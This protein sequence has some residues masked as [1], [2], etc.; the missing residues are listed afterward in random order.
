MKEEDK[1]G[2]SSELKERLLKLAQLGETD[3]L[4]DQLSA[5]MHLLNEVKDWV[6]KY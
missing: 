2:A 3:E 5:N 1:L 4:R 6:Q